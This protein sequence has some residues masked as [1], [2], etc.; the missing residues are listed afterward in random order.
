MT[1]KTRGIEPCLADESWSSLEESASPLQRSV[2]RSALNFDYLYKSQS[3]AENAHVGSKAAA[4][5]P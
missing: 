4:G 5:E 2:N 3:T 1:K